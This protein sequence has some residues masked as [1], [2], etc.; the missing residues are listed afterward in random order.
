MQNYFR[1]FRE[2]RK[3]RRVFWFLGILVL[4]C[5]SWKNSKTTERT[6]IAYKNGTMLCSEKIKARFDMKGQI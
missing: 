3:V 6:N 5:S 4:L 2:R 1:R